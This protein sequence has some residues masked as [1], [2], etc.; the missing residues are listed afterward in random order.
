MSRTSNAVEK[1]CVPYAATE[2]YLQM[3]ETRLAL[4]VR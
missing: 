1:A 2:V 4:K 3:E